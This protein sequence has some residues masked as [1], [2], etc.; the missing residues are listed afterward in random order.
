MRNVLTTFL[1]LVL[2]GCATKPTEALGPHDFKFGLLVGDSMK[3]LDVTENKFIIP[4][5]VGTKLPYFGFKI[6]PD[7][8]KPYSIQTVIYLP[9]P[10]KTTSGNLKGQPQDYATG[11]KSLVKSYRGRS[12]IGYRLEPGDPCGDYK[13]V[14]LINGKPWQEVNYKVVPA[15]A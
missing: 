3:S 10:P 1:I 14:V 12:V 7:H 13:L 8:N 11:I 2:A 5:K 6:I 15:N 9:A 4:Y